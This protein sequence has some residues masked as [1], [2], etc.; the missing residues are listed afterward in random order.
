M[1]KVFFT[2]FVALS[3]ATLLTANTIKDDKAIKHTLLKYNYGIIKMAKSGETDFFKTFVKKEVVTKLML[4][5]KSWQDNNLVMIADINDFQFSPIIYNE[6]NA[7]MTT[8]EE[9]TFSYVNIAT[10]EIALEPVDIYYEM[11]YTLEKKGDSWM[12][13]EIKHL[14]EKIT[15]KKKDHAP[16]L[17]QNKEN[18]KEK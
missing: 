2:I 11:R 14:K 16:E 17:K 15:Q 7:T 13:V 12:I 3:C 8:R 4:W 9:W 10:K 18:I 6:D 1:K 5:V